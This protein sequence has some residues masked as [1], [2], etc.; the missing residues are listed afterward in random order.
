MRR[1]FAL[2]LVPALA[3]AGVR[4]DFAVR[5]VDESLS[6]IGASMPP[7]VTQYF[8]EGGKVR[9]GG[10]NAKLVYVFKEGTMYVIDNPAHVVHVLR[11][12]TLREVIAHYA[13][14][15][16]Q[17][18]QAAANAP[19]DQRAAALQKAA[20]MKAASDRLLATVPRDYRMTTRFESADGRACRVWEEWEN[21]AKRLELCV[22]QVATIPGGAEI[23]KGMETLSRFRQGSDFAFG[24]EFGLDEWWRDFTTL[25]GIPI[26]V[27][28]YKYD[29]V[30]NE[31]MLT[32]MHPGVAGTLWD[33]P[34]DYPTENGPD[35]SQW[36]MH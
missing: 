21:G 32:S 35:Y 15:V 8:V 11:H 17:L 26:L 22:A 9:V 31:V 23:L 10:T 34:A 30:I 36:Y 33:L 29:A 1:L 20:D 4:Y 24:V 5:P 16:Q 28:E 12:A 3:G 25:G 2:L 13:D 27:R 6:Q 7:V 18:A 19:P 14:A